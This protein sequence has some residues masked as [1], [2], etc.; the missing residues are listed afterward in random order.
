MDDRDRKLPPTL[1][2]AGRT[3]AVEARG[4]PLHRLPAKPRS[5]HPPRVDGSLRTEGPA[6]AQAVQ[7]LL[8]LQLE[9]PQATRECL[10]EPRQRQ[11]RGRPRKNREGET[12]G[13][14]QEQP[15]RDGLVG[16]LAVMKFRTE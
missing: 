7:E 15:R 14:R 16:R 4:Q 8:E 12:A 9:M 3:N 1:P 13:R 10:Q 5:R 2:P 11:E 6:A